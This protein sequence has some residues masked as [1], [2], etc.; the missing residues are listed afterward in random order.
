MRQDDT[1]LFLGASSFDVLYNKIRNTVS[2]F[3]TS[4]QNLLTLNFFKFV[5]MIFSRLSSSAGNDHMLVR[6]NVIKRIA[7]TKY[8]G[9]LIDEN[10][11]WKNHSSLIAEKL[12]RGFG[13]MRRIK[14]L[15]PKKILK[16]IYFSIF[17]PYISYGC[18]TWANN[19]VTCFKR[20]QKLQNRAIKLLLEFYDSDEIPSHEHFKKSKLMDVF[21]IQN[22]QV[23]IFSYKCLDRLLTPA[24]Q[25]LFTFNRDRHDHN[26]R[27]AD[28]LT[29]EFRS[30]HR[31]SFVI[32]PL[33]FPCLEY[34]LPECVK[35]EPS[36]PLSKKFLLSRE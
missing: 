2:E 26:T 13:V 16:M 32:R 31:A 14:N 9:F 15:V 5:F 7:T 12:S 19:F 23:A 21:K 34:V 6:G 33:W 3:P 11:S 10:L 28:N 22:Y 30:T 35:N 18:S 27:K 29:H 4:H 20:V 17:C 25:N 24:F 36:L 1:L 8:L